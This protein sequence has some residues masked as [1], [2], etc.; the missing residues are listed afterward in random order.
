MGLMRH[1]DPP[2]AAFFRVAQADHIRPRG[3]QLPIPQIRRTYP[4]KERQTDDCHHSGSFVRAD[5]R[6]S[7]T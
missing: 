3:R 4:P 1:G 6:L 7:L 5:M 2:Q